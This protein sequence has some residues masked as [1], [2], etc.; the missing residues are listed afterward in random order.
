M[1]TDSYD[2]AVILEDKTEM[3]LQQRLRTRTKRPFKV[4]PKEPL[5]YE[6]KYKL[7]LKSSVRSKRFNSKLKGDITAGLRQKRTRFRLQAS[8]SEMKTEI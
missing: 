3:R 6:T 1:N 2:G 5:K 4:V 7:T 8:G